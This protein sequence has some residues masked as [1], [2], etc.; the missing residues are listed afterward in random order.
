MRATSDASLVRVQDQL[1]NLLHLHY[2][3]RFDPAGLNQNER[4]ALRQE[5][6]LC[7]KKVTA[8]SR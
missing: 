4:N 8:A 2:R 7:L 1:R 5:A 3:Y 6:G